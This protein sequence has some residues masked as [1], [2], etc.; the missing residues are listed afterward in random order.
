MRSSRGLNRGPRP[1]R[2]DFLSQINQ[3]RRNAAPTK[4]HDDSLAVEGR[5]QLPSAFARAPLF[6]VERPFVL[7]GTVPRTHEISPRRNAL[8][9][10]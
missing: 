2:S 1:N 4:E 8:R 9:V 5:H 7:T 10:G 3:S 6:G